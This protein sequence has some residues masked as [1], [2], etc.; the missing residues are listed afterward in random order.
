MLSLYTSK[1]DQVLIEAGELEKILEYLKQARQTDL[2][3]YKRSSLARRIPLRMQQISIKSYRD[4][5]NYL[6][7]HPDEV[8]QLLNTIFINFTRFFRDQPLWDYLQDQL[9]PQIIASKSPDAPIRMWSAGCATGE[10]TYSLAIL[11]AEALGPEQF[12]QRVRL[13]GTDVDQE[14]LREARQGFYPRRVAEAI[15]ASLQQKYF[16]QTEFS[17]LWRSELRSPIRF[18]YHNLMQMPPLPR[19]DLLLCRNTLMYFNPDIQLRVLVRFHFSLN[20]N[21]FLA[22]GPVENPNVYC[23]RHP[24]FTSVQRP[25]NVFTKV[26]NAHR[27][28]NLLGKAFCA[29]QN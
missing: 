26:P 20:D 17:Y 16:E 1:D 25:A 6:A 13:Y 28:P 5:R 18:C 12:R 3:G 27:N 15:P 19:I 29:I 23:P 9:I 24:L 11:L 4:Y 7:Q 2:T 10:E 22:L 14:A 21:G 8:N